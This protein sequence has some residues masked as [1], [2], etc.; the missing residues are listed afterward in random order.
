MS[1]DDYGRPVTLG[2]ARQLEG[3]LRGLSRDEQARLETW[4]SHY[5][6][7][8]STRQIETY[9]NAVE[10]N[11]ARYGELADDLVQLEGLADSIGD[12]V[13]NGRLS[14]RDGRQQITAIA[15][16]IREIREA[17]AELRAADE[18]AWTEVTR[19]PAE[20]QNEIIRKFPA[21]RD[22]LKRFGNDVVYGS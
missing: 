13:R 10:R 1:I 20:V 11:T 5:D 18:R 4:V 2:E 22:K 17:A 6:H 16:A 19:D 7:E 8:V 9:T 3:G 14:A 12:D 15:R 21:L